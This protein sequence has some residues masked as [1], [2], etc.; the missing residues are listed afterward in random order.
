MNEFRQWALC[1]IVTAAAGTFVCAVSPR[2]TT[3]KAVRS[4]V[5]IFVVVTVCTPL[6]QLEKTELAK[7]VFSDSYFMSDSSDDLK[8][9]VLEQCKFSV[10]EQLAPVAEKHSVT[11]CSV[12]MDAYFD[13]Y[14]SI[15]IQNIHLDI[16]SENPESA[17]LFMSEAQ[18][19]LGVP[20]TS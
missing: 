8:E 1:L 5:G 4:V 7:D 3:E 17:V 2:G 13:E 12:A 20:I 19:M 6:T 16:I 9:Q 15:I 11:V 10:E 14:N 18:E